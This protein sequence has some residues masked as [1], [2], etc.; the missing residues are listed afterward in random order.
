MSVEGGAVLPIRLSLFAAIISI[1]AVSL[2]GC[3]PSYPETIPVSGTV[4]LDGQTIAGAAVVFT[5]E[6][7]RQATG[8]T[9]SS[10]RFEL[11]TFRLGDGALPGPHRVTVSKTTVGDDGKIVFLIPR[12]Y[13]NQQTSPL[14][15][16][17]QKK[18]AEVRF[19][20]LVESEGNPKPK[21]SAAGGADAA[22]DE[23]SL[24]AKSGE[25]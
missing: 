13:G 16:D 17:V 14:T 24:G 21:A 25:E 1:F 12:V 20:L 5:P 18:M 8:T 23:K 19:D 2:P 9:D 3:G 4:T 7:G 6:E 10:G 15:C 11:S 22:E